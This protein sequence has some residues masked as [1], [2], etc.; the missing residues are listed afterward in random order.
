MSEKKSNRLAEGG[1]LFASRLILGATR[2]TSRMSE[3]MLQKAAA[4]SALPKD[5]LF[6]PEDIT[7]SITVKSL[8][9]KERWD[10]LKKTAPAFLAERGFLRKKYPS[11]KSKIEAE[12]QYY[13]KSIKKQSK[14]NIIL[15]ASSISKHQSIYEHFSQAEVSQDNL[16]LLMTIPQ[17]L[18]EYEAA[19]T[20]CAGDF[21]GA[22]NKLS[23]S[24][25]E[26]KVDSCLA[27]F[28][29]ELEV[30]KKNKL[31]AVNF[32]LMLPDNK[33]ITLDMP[34]KYFFKYIDTALLMRFA[35]DKMPDFP[36]RLYF[37][38]KGE[39]LFEK[40]LEK[41]FMA[42]FERN[43]NAYSKEHVKDYSVVINRTSKKPY[44][45][46][47]YD[48]VKSRHQLMTF[49][50]AAYEDKEIP[51]NNLSDFFKQNEDIIND[52]KKMIR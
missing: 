11:L 1:Y 22:I 45:E 35:K 25:S 48:G 17:F 2:L 31:Q 44:P 51:L 41:R 42:D 46:S 43:F 30:A 15:M 37:G 8:Q 21:D 14:D 29:R 32:S 33:H 5:Y 12:Q 26:N 20:E 49:I 36:C 28:E 47:S 16:G 9:V 50:E 10:M 40:I 4:A 19:I 6:Y 7:Q 23:E 27:P 52:V 13:L 38:E 34:I 24:V 18:A 39:F 3:R